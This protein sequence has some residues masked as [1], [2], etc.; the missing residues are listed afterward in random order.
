MFFVLCEGTSD[1]I[2]AIDETEKGAKAL[3]WAKV[4]EYLE[5]RGAPITSEMTNAELE[6]FF[7]CVVIEIKR[8]AEFLKS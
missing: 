6:N 7:G 4:H 3:L 5:D 8:G 1:E 2:Y